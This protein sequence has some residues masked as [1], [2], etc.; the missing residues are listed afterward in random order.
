MPWAELELDQGVIRYRDSGEGQP[1]IVFVHGLLVDGRLWDA[2]TPR[3]HGHR[4]IVPD[5]PLGAHR[6]ALHAEA[7]LSPP[8]LARVV[9]DALQ[10][11]DLDQVTLVANDTGGAIAQLVV[12]RHPQRIARLVLTNCDAYE[13]FLPPMFRP[14][15]V[16]ARMPGLPWVVSNAMRSARARNL[17]IA[18]GRLTRTPID[19]A[20]SAD[21]LEPLR[22]NRGVRRDAIKLLRGISNRYTIDA[23]AALHTFPGPTL[24]A[25]GR[26]DPVFKPAYA[27]RLA[28]DSANATLEWID[29]SG[30]FVPIDQPERLAE[31]IGRFAAPTDQPPG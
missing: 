28:A 3:L 2:V 17:P 29:Q 1:A 10:A 21:W 5:W 20:L 22:M 18:F 9:A 19:P 23:A 16:A 4:L 15:Q 7:D 27:Q 12:T 31:L 11:L 24:I 14:L 6:L 13:N 8:G 25:W 26:D 30:A